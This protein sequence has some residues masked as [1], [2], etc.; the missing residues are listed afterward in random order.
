MSLKEDNFAPKALKKF[1]IKNI[2][3]DNLFTYKMQLG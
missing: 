1:D 2:I 3:D